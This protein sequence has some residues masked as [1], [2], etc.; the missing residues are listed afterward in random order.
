MQKVIPDILNSFFL[1]IIQDA[2]LQFM[3]QI[4]LIPSF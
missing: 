1:E 4:I 2:L 3:I